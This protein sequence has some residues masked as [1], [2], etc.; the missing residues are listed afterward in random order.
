MEVVSQDS[1][2]LR[3][4]PTYNVK[5][6]GAQWPICA[7][8]V[9]LQNVQNSALFGIPRVGLLAR[10]PFAA[11]FL[12]HHAFVAEWFC[13][14]RECSVKRAESKLSLAKPVKIGGATWFHV[15]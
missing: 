8:E 14:W 12:L 15:Q 5:R 11:E 4:V 2:R 3:Q 10:F 1:A 9:L 6:S 7:L 13:S